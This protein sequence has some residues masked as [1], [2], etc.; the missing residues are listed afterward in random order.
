MANIWYTDAYTDGVAVDKADVKAGLRDNVVAYFASVA[1]FEATSTASLKFAVV[2]GST[3]ELDASD[4]TSSSDGATL[5][6]SADGGRYDL[7]QTGLENRTG[8]VFSVKDLKY[9]ATGD[10]TT[11]DTAAINAALADAGLVAGIVYFPP[12]TYRITEALT[13]PARPYR[14]SIQGAGSIATTILYKPSTDTAGEI[15]ETIDLILQNCHYKGF[16]LKKDSSITATVYAWKG[17]SSDTY[18]FHSLAH[19]ED[20]RVVDC[21]YGFAVA[22]AQTTGFFDCTWIDIYIN[23]SGYGFDLRGSQNCIMRPYIVNCTTAGMVAKYASANSALGAQIYGGT[24]GGNETDLLFPTASELRPIRFFGT[25]FEDST[26]GVIT[27]TNANTALKN[28]S[29]DGCKFQSAS[30][31][32]ALLDFSNLIGTISVSNSTVSKTT[33]GQNTTITPPSS[34]NGRLTLLDNLSIDHTLTRTLLDNVIDGGLDVAGGSLTVD[35]AGDSAAAEGLLSADD[36][37]AAYFGMQTGGSFRWAFIKTAV[38]ETGSDAGSDFTIGRYNDSG[39][40]QDSP[41]TIVRANGRVVY[42]GNV[43][44]TP[45]T[46]A[47]LPAAFAGDRHVVS[48]ATATTFNSVV[49]GGGANVVPVYNDG[50]NWRIG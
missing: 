1:A 8:G 50:T 44:Q 10:G 39:V 26:D 17:G 45:V 22:D 19:F 34:A 9:G 33:A 24:F 5:L 36:G 47:A 42:S 15:F 23:G 27:V 35:R 38:S 32:G 12:G 31:S 18:Q 6:V 29:F 16:A 46:V 11:D 41:I 7:I 25:W 30:T 37:Q 13:Y 49:A 40:F 3:Y 14:C 43:G 4:T 20:I 28:L 21:D 48:D 2:D